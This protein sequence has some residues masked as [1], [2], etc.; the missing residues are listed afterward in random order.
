SCS[1]RLPMASTARRALSDVSITLYHRRQNRDSSPRICVGQ[2]TTKSLRT[3]NMH[4]SGR[5]LLLGIFLISLTLSVQ[6]QETAESCLKEGKQKQGTG[7]L[8]G[9]LIDYDK[10]IALV[11]AD[12]KK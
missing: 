11:Q 9:A 8:E 4:R 6:G 7:D 5:L 3:M 12:A 1:V 2:Q 10:V